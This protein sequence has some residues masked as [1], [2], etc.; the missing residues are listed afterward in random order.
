MR[1]CTGNNTQEWGADAIF[2]VECKN[3][4]HVITMS[5]KVVGSGR[6]YSDEFHF[7]GECIWAKGKENVKIIQDEV[8]QSVPT[9]VKWAG[10]VTYD[11]NVDLWRVKLK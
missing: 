8:I 10:E 6:I 2:D 11:P 5:S 4:G 1:K 9:G 3:C 7:D